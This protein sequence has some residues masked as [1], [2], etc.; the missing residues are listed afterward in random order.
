VVDSAKPDQLTW[1]QVPDSTAFLEMWPTTQ[2]EIVSAKYIDPALTAPLGGLIGK[3]WGEAVSHPKIPL[4]DVATGGAATAAG[5]T[6][7]GGTTTTGS[8][9]ASTVSAHGPV[10]DDD[11]PVTPGDANSGAAVAGGEVQYHLLRAFDYSVKPGKKYRYRVTLVLGNPNAGSLP[12]YLQ[13]PESAKAPS[14]SSAVSPATS[15]VTIPDGHDVLAGTIVSAGSKYSEPVAKVV[16]TAIHSASGL[17]P[18]TELDVRRGTMANTPARKVKVRNPLDK[19]VHELEVGFDSNILVLDIFGGKDLAKR[20]HETP[21]TT[22]GE[23]LLFD[24]NGNMTVRSELDDQTEYNESL[25]R[26]E[27]KEKP[28]ALEEKDDEAPRAIKSKN[29]KQQ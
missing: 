2:N 13:D 19:Q 4:G 1:E 23:I 9:T 20:K 15:L 14:L 18:A 17:K 22:P 27:P 29:K 16:V 8:T 5:G 3:Q 10:P 7:S 24:S 11:P 21:I 28:K 26:E 12:Q 6:A 25:V